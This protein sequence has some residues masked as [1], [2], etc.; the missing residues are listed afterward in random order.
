M[1][2]CW[3]AR[4]SGPTASV[5]VDLLRSQRVQFDFEE[6]DDVDRAFDSRRTSAPS[7]A[8]FVVEARRKNGRLIVT[9]ADGDGRALTVV[10]DTGSQV[11][12]GNQALRDAPAGP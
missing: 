9:D 10:L 8:R 2:P 5:G 11:S 6:P 7:R 3:K 4:T 1:P 12:I